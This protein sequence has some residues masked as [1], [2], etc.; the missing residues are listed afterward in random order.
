MLLNLLEV[1]ALTPLNWQN[2]KPTFTILWQGL[3]AIFVVIGLIL[4]AVNLITF[5]VKKAE[6]ALK[7]REEKTK[8]LSAGGPEDEER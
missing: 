3:L 4:V 1:S 5:F 7:A 6:D 8:N 2:I